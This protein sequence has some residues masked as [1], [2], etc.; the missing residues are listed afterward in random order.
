MEN[1]FITLF[2]G[3]AMLSLTLFLIFRRLQ[4]KTARKTIPGL[5]PTLPEHG[6]LPDIGQAGS[7]HQF[8]LQLHQR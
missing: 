6:N 1:T 2:L 8:L 5:V 7:M 4:R 3:I